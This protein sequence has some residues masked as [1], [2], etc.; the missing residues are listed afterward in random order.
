[1]VNLAPDSDAERVRRARAGDQD[2]WRAIWMSCRPEAYRM[3]SGMLRSREEREDAVQ[4]TFARLFQ[5]LHDFDP[6]L[7]SLES[8]VASIARRV[9]LDRLRRLKKLGVVEKAMRDAAVEQAERPVPAEVLDAL[10]RHL[11]MCIPD[12]LGRKIMDLRMRKMRNKDIA[13]AIGK[14]PGTVSGYISRVRKCIQ[15]RMRKSQQSGD[16]T[17][18][19]G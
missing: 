8:Y 7:G 13:Q 2:A 18:S 19:N 6:E 16:S 3:A 1:M 14:H 12:A 10:M 11:E 15:A 9:C 17:S 5:Y 4:D